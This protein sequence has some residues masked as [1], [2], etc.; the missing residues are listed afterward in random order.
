MIL[1]DFEYERPGTLEDAVKLIAA[2]GDARAL[3]GGTDL[4]PNM[5]VAN[6]T[7]ALLVSLGGIDPAPPAEGSGGALTVDALMRLSD[8]EASP[9]VRERAPMLAESALTV[10]GNQ[11]RVMGTLGG[12]LCQEP[13]CLYLNQEHDYQFVAPCYKRGGDCCYPFPGNDSE[14]CWAVY[15]SDI[16][17]VL[18]ALDAEIEILGEGGARSIPADALF[19]GNGLSPLKLASSE[20]ICSVIVPP[21]AP[22]TGWGYHKTT[23]R[24]GLD[25]ATA[26]IA[27]TLILA[28]DGEA[29]AGARLVFGAVGEGPL[30]ASGT[31]SALIGQ[32][33][34]AENLA[35][36]ADDAAREINP[37]P[38][39][40][41]NKGYLREN[42]RVYL[43]RTLAAA[44]ERA[45]A[46]QA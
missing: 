27:V 21:A 37:L 33:L 4:L 22:G 18:I 2:S 42:I 32:S 30:R 7:P 43:R 8:L 5:R 12:N 13:R 24:G 16:A 34:D 1:Q 44:L 36:A 20:L 6:L 31:E 40:G 3:A 10:A 41:F 25:F 26:I 46:A 45:R 29:C 38:H 17:P 19:T 35:R 23:V 11:I 39:H 14:T 9:L 28:D 15:M